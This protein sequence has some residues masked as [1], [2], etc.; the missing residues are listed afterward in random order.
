M[1]E[2]FRVMWFRPRSFFGAR[3]GK[4]Y[5]VF[6]RTLRIT[7]PFPSREQ[8]ERHRDRIAEL[9]ERWGFE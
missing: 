8:A 2:R 7:I 4:G 9:Y 3:G 6:D 5:A 1:S